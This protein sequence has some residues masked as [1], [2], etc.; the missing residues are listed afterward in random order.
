MNTLA[1]P[2][3]GAVLGTWFIAGTDAHAKNCSL[4]LASGT[5]GACLTQRN[6]A[7]FRALLSDRHIQVPGR[8]FNLAQGFA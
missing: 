3:N 4:L 5:G 2:L 7:V 8:R 6:V 1:V